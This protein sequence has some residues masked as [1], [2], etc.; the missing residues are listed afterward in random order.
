MFALF[1]G[2]GQDGQ[3]SSGEGWR[4]VA[5]TALAESALVEALLNDEQLDDFWTNASEESPAVPES[6][7]SV[8]FED[9]Y[10]LVVSTRGRG[11]DPTEPC[12]VF[13]RGL[14]ADRDVGQV[15]VEFERNSSD[16]A[17]DLMYIPG[18]YVVAVSWELT[19]PPPF[20]VVID[21]PGQAG[22]PP[23]VRI[24]DVD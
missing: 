5:S 4:L 14:R 13:F 16:G 3:A 8:L 1:A 9:E 11:T 19:G 6:P 21:E 7:P 18:Q 20:D 23:P 10:V 12:G 22:Q 24:Q 17:C 15:V 2:C